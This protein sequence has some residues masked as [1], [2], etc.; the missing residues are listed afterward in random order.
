MLSEKVRGWKDE[1]WSY[2]IEIT[3]A[4]CYFEE[5]GCKVKL[6][7]GRRRR[8][9]WEVPKPGGRNEM[10]NKNFNLHDF[11]IEFGYGQFCI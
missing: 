9:Y 1:T 3:F 7:K 11:N 8:R 10:D 4:I 6:L 2:F 5:K